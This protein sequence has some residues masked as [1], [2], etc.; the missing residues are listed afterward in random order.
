MTLLTSSGRSPVTSTQTYGSSG[1]AIDLRLER[2]APAADPRRFRALAVIA[3]AQLMIVLD[4]SVVTVA[5][6]SAQHALHISNSDRQWVY[7]AYSL[8][9]G[10]LLLLGGRVSDYLGRKRT[11]IVSLLGFAA[12]SALG[13][14]AQSGAMLFGARVYKVV[15]RP[16]M[17]PAGAVADNCDL[18]R[19]ASGPRLSGST[20]PSPAGA[21]PSA[22]CSA[23]C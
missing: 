12:A 15:S 3:I 1:Q 8:A 5:L 6:P 18:H 9:F 14:L 10:G 13:G 22:S 2:T 4:A 16:L 7:T 23:A 11:F 17:A 20:A 19:A 21:R